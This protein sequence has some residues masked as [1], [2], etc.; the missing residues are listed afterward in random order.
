MYACVI[1]HNMIV[2]NEIDSYGIP[3]DNTYEQP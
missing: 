3:D 2:Q 1:L